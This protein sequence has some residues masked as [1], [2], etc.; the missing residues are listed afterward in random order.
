VLRSTAV[1]SGVEH[2]RSGRPRRRPLPAAE[3]RSVRRRQRE[4]SLTSN[5]AESLLVNLREWAKLCFAILFLLLCL[6]IL[7]AYK[8]GAYTECRQ[9][10]R[11]PFMCAYEAI[12]SESGSD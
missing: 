1:E 11:S 10:G 5:K 3:P 7:S 4:G 9:L 8:F 6:A 12:F 2:L